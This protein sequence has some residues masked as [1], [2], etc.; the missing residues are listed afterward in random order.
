MPGSY[1]GIDLNYSKLLFQL[2]VTGILN[3]FTVSVHFTQ[4]DW[5]EVQF[6]VPFTIFSSNIKILHV[7]L[8]IVVVFAVFINGDRFSR[9]QGSCDEHNSDLFRPTFQGQ[10]SSDGRHKTVVPQTSFLYY[11]RFCNA[12]LTRVQIR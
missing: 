2:L 8:I 9:L 10:S 5:G 3:Q 7:V 12:Q 4:A 1:P 11:A 6:V